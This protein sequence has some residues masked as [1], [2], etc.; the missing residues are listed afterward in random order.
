MKF[1]VYNCDFFVVINFELEAS[2]VVF[3]S[4]HHICL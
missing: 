3:Y 4:L 1:A 2:H